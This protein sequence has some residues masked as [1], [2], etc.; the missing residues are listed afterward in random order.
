MC[1]EVRLH[2]FIFTTIQIERERP[3]VNQSCFNVLHVFT[4]VY[5]CISSISQ[6]FSS[7]LSFSRLCLNHFCG[8]NKKKMG[9]GGV[10]FSVVGLI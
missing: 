9:R 10:K 6:G 3:G 4:C 5:L 7:L 8:L 1:K 2:N